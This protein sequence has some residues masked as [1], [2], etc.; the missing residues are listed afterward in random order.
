MKKNLKLLIA[1]IFVFVFVLQIAP[2]ALASSCT[3]NVTL[4]KQG[5]KGTNVACLQQKLGMTLNTYGTFGPTTKAVVIKFQKENNLKADGIVGAGTIKALNNKTSEIPSTTPTTETTTPT[6]CPNGN[7]VASNCIISPAGV[8]TSTNVT[9]PSGCTSTLGYS[10]TTGQ[11]CGVVSSSL[12]AGCTSSAGWSSTTGQLCSGVSSSLPAGCTS[13]SGWS[14]TTGQSCNS[15]VTSSNNYTVSFNQNNVTISVG[16]SLT[17]IM[18]GNPNS[19]Y[20]V[21]NNSNS[22]VVSASIVSDNL[23]LYGYNP[24]SS[25]ILVCPSGSTSCSTLYVTVHQF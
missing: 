20:F 24:G 5:S 11:S 18:N 8:V 23:R 3:I 13:T 19:L 12:S 14:P 7:T 9:Y 1:F 17:I 10:S 22:S 16:Q 15:T 2:K 25:N 21:S 6:L 4:L